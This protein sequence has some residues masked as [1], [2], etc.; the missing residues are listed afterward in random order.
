MLT[1]VPQ[2]IDIV[3]DAA[4]LDRIDNPTANIDTSRGCQS[5]NEQ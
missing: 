1:D 5:M 4:G 3:Y 2:A